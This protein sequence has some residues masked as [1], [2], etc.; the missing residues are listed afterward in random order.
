MK[1]DKLSDALNEI[2]DEHIARAT[3]QRKR[4]Y[5][6]W[7]SAVAAVLAVVILAGIFIGNPAFTDDP[8]IGGD[9]PTLTDPP[10]SNLPT[11]APG[12][13]L[14]F[15]AAAP[16]YP[17]MSP[18]PVEYDADAYTA[19]WTDVRDIHDQPLYYGDNLKDY[20]SALIPTLLADA[21]AENAVCSPV[22][23]YMALAMLAET[24]GG[25]SRQQLMELLNADSIESLRTQAGYVW[26][27]HYWNDGLSTSILANS[28]WLEEG[29]PFRE[30]CVQTLAQKYYASVFQGD[31]GSE[32]MDACLQAWLNEQTGGLLQEQVQNA[33]LSDVS[34]MALASTLNYQVQWQDKFWDKNNTE[35]VF[36][37]S[38]GDTDVTF[39]NQEIVFGTYYWG[40][41]FAAISLLLED[42][43]CMWLILPDEGKTPGDILESGNAM[44]LLSA[45]PMD[46]PDQKRIRINLSVPKFDVCSD[47][48]LQDS[49]KA[50]GIT[51]IFDGEKAD[52]SP[53]LSSDD[54]GYISIIQHATRV[55][56]DE[57]GVTAAAFTLILR[58]G[59][60]M[61]PEDHIDFILDR[62]FL[63]VIQ[64]NDG[65]PL[66]S[67]I[68]NQP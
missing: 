49:L 51:D 61:P 16:K 8:A 45:S 35:G 46:Y 30:S 40:A 36:H 56:I 25:N 63:F 39:M 42:N 29:Y 4:S 6:P 1:H 26:N 14:Q 9:L 11:Q 34:S 66:F 19:W 21:G 7:I 67:G 18:Y 2:R 62:P 59:A 23:I 44:T 10:A 65:L 15:L 20:F 41:D 31:L 24:T 64:S 38:A 12:I 57:E 3:H 33:K 68:V 17:Q 22:N 47:M 13:Q 5:A 28:L 32:E 54:G 48:Q 60:A 58:D 53:L 27:A 55:A 37:A 52:F 50:L 43:G